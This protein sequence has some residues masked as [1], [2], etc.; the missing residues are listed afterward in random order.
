VPEMRARY[1]SEKTTSRKYV[2]GPMPRIFVTAIVL[3]RKGRFVTYRRDYSY[4]KQALRWCRKWSF[5]DES[6]SSAEI[7]DLSRS[8]PPHHTWTGRQIWNDTDGL[9]WYYPNVSPEDGAPLA[10]RSSG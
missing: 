2:R 7:R 8:D 1:H 9:L 10:T 5:N 3:R 4:L 6:F